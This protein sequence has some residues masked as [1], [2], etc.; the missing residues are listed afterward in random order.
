M[1]NTLKYR[2][3][4]KKDSHEISEL[5]ISTGS[6]LKEVDFT[7]EGWEFFVE[8]NQP[9]IVKDRFDEGFTSMGAFKNEELVAL[10]TIKDNRHI[11]Q[12]FVKKDCQGKGISS[13][14]WALV[15]NITNDTKAHKEYT[16]FSSSLAIP[17][18]ESFGF[19]V[20][21]P[22]QEKNGIYY[23]PMKLLKR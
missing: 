14:L 23:R 22:P 21:D 15:E 12:L 2:N 8:V 18:Y 13:R 19:Q 3:L 10:I 5:V 4:S 7:A 20:T 17:V 9:D 16:V 11:T 1:V 6:L